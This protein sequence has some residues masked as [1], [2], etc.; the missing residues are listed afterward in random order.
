M[1]QG[2]YWD[3]SIELL[4]GKNVFLTSIS[5]SAHPTLL[6]AEHKALHTVEAPLALHIVEAQLQEIK[7]KEGQ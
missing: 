4:E 7:P 2:T 5:I 1:T 3:I 6:W